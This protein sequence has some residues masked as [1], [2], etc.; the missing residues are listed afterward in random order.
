MPDSQTP[1]AAEAAPDRSSPAC[2]ARL[3]FRDGLLAVLIALLAQLIIA[4]IQ[5]GLDEEGIDFPASI[6]AM[7]GVFAMLSVFGW[8]IPGMEV[9]YRQRLKRAVRM[10]GNK[11]A[12]GPMEVLTKS[13]GSAKPPHVHRIYRTLH[14]DIPGSLF[15]CTDNWRRH[16]MLR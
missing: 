1:I 15:G 14:H 2:P 13:G 3:D 10:T 16:T 6:L 8:V 9:F 7:A 12:M 4:G 5:H 11:L